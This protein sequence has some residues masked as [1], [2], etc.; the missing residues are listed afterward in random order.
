MYL[1][2]CRLGVGAKPSALPTSNGSDEFEALRRRLL[3]RRGMRQER[4]LL[5]SQAGA[6]AKNVRATGGAGLKRRREEDESSSDEEE[7]R[8]AMLGS[9]KTRHVLDPAPAS[10]QGEQAHKREAK[11]SGDGDEAQSGH[12]SEDNKP[13]VAEDGETHVI[14]HA[15]ETP[16]QHASNNVAMDLKNGA[17]NYYLDEVLAERKRKREKKKKKKKKRKKLDDEE[18][19]GLA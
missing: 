7:G 15:A 1:M 18:P 11:A 16:A 9:K 2:Y 10:E 5:R 13:E 12:A 19:Q 6:K 14:T 3:G 8:A 4:E 17:A